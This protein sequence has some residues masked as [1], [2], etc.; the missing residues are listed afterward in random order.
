MLTVK[1]LQDT[2]AII[3]D[4][5]ASAELF[6]CITG[7]VL[8]PDTRS[9]SDIDIVVVLPAAV[10]V[11]RALALR[12]EFT[13][14]YVAL[15]HTHQRTPDLTWPGEVLYLDDLHHALNGAAFARNPHGGDTPELCPD[16]QPYRYWISMIA[17]GH[18]LTGPAAFE[19]NADACADLIARHATAAGASQDDRHDYWQH[20]WHLPA[21]PVSPRTGRIT[22]HM[23]R[24][25]H[26]A[27][28]VPVLSPSTVPI[29]EQHQDRWRGI[30]REQAS[31]YIRSGA[32]I[33]RSSN[34]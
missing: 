19:Q 7:S 9:G 23:H 6:S 5:F 32:A 21:P 4:V 18:P 22:H 13:R 25:T 15:H 10:P 33:P 2:A 14:R 29:L 24:A 34:P 30:A 31:G 16:D 8:D 1:L 11:P 3:E 28:P 20:T 26:R 12:A 17:T 27:S